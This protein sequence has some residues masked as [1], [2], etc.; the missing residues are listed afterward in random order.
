MRLSMKLVAVAFLMIMVTNCTNKHKNVVAVER[1]PVKAI[2]VECVPT[3]RKDQYVGS[4]IES[5]SSILSFEVPGNVKQ[6]LVSVGDRVA[7]GQL[8]AILDKGNIANDYLS[9]EATLK[10]AKD[11]C[12]RMTMLY[13]SKSIPK[14]QL[15]DAQTQLDKAMA[16]EQAAK[17]NETDCYLYAPFAGVIGE[18]HIDPGVNVTTGFPAFKLLE[19]K[20]LKADVS[21]PEDE[22]GNIHIGS[23]ALIS[24]NVLNNLQLTGT[25][26]QKGVIGNPLSHSYE[27]KIRLTN[28]SKE[29][30]P[31]MLCNVSIVP[32]KGKCNIV[33]PANCIQLYEDNNK[34]V[35]VIKDGRVYLRK[36]T[37][38]SFS[39]NEVIVGSGL[40][41]GDKIVSEGFQKI[42]EGAVVTEK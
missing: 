34:Y 15:I 25:V 30:M 10:Q 37:I 20:T 33:I 39:E 24:I 14:V 27:V 8:L 18:R 35:W 40:Q 2:T 31:G 9:A 1:I 23:K 21:I 7:K 41:A 38:S 3:Y 28:L 36:V 12:K 16:A 17:R 19:V 42:S 4:I 32:D 26:D 29:I 5:Q 11:N 6:V 22:I 13:K